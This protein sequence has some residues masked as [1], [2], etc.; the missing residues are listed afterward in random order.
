M[1]DYSFKCL[2]CLNLGPFLIALPSLSLSDF[3]QPVS[4]EN[5]EIGQCPNLAP[6]PPP[7]PL[8]EDEEP[9]K[10][11]E[12]T[13]PVSPPLTPAPVSPPPELPAVSGLNEHGK[14]S[15]LISC[16]YVQIQKCEIWKTAYAPYYNVVLLFSYSHIYTQSNTQYTHTSFFLMKCHHGLAVLA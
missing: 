7:L 5:A 16:M 11:K 2:L 4:F 1:S 15:K 13:K 12:E 9:E 6:A 3:S 14:T 10:E 8:P